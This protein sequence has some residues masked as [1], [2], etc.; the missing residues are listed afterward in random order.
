MV[1]SPSGHGITAYAFRAITPLKKIIKYT[2][3]K[4]V[5]KV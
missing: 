4:I 3:P 5:G 2:L 1:I